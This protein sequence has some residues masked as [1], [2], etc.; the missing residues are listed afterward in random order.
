MEKQLQDIEVKIDRID[1]EVQ[2]IASNHLPHLYQRMNTVEK[3]M[4]SLRTEVHKW[5]WKMWSAVISAVASVFGILLTL[6]NMLM[7][8]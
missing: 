4:S 6:I 7:G 3:S 8:G 5:S 2:S 1:K